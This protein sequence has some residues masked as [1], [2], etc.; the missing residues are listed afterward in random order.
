MLSLPIFYVPCSLI[1]VFVIMILLT[2]KGLFRGSVHNKKM[3]V[4]DVI[5]LFSFKKFWQFFLV[6]IIISLC[7]SFILATN[8]V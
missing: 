7:F 6:L 5:G 4:K 3:G 1:A 2:N 8:P